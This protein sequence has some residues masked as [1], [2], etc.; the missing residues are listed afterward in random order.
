MDMSKQLEQFNLQA[1]KANPEGYEYY[2]L[3]MDGKAT[4]EQLTQLQA[5]SNLAIP[6]SLRGF[7]EKNGGIVPCYTYNVETYLRIP[8]VAQLLDDLN[9]NSSMNVKYPKLTRKGM[10]LIDSIRDSWGNDR[11][12]F[13]EGK[14]FSANDLRFLNENYK[15]FGLYRHNLESAWYLYFDQH[16]NFGE[17]HYDQDDFNALEEH[18]RAMLVKSPAN[19]NLDTLLHHALKQILLVCADSEDKMKIILMNF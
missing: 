16:G 8:S 7:Y 2:L 3:K 19:Y 9:E 13:E 1:E 11:W 15:G 17:I 4:Q 5:Y 12:E 10:G 6:E 18:L 14:F